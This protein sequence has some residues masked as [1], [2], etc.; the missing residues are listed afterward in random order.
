MDL[1]MLEKDGK[2]AVLGNILSDEEFMELMSRSDK[3]EFSLII[4]LCG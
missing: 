4:L 3:Q 1:R 2:V